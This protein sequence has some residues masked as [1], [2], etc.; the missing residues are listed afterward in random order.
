MSE[1]RSYGELENLT[2][3]ESE[4]ALCKP[5]GDSRKALR[6]YCPFHGSDK[7]RSLRVNMETGHF[8]CFA[9]G[10]WGYTEDA[11]KERG[12]LA[13]P[14]HGERVG[15]H[16]P[17]PKRVYK[18]KPEPEPRAELDALMESYR[19]ALP[20]SPGETYLL[21]RH[22]P[23]Q[24]AQ[25]LGVG[26][27]APGRWHNPKRDWK[28]G[29]LVFPHTTPTGELVNVYGRAVGDAPK[30]L[31]H[32]HLAGAKGYFNAQ[33][34]AH[35]DGP[36]TICEGAFDALALIAAGA[37]GVIA[38]F[39]V[40]GW[41]WEW[42]KEAGEMIL[43]LDSDATGASELQELAR[44]AKLRGKRIAYLEPGAYG[45]EKDASAAWSAG[46]LKLGEWEPLFSH[47]AIKPLS[48]AVV[49]APALSWEG[50]LRLSAAL[51]PKPWYEGVCMAHAYLEK[52]PAYMRSREA[53][54]RGAV[55]ELAQD[56]EPPEALA[57]QL[58]AWSRATHMAE[59]R[60]PSELPDSWK[61][62]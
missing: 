36:V 61:A 34:L 27:S 9:C 45:E 39:G 40:N 47:D 38:I 1:H 11:R 58:V 44:Q 20:G 43:A 54:L 52:G 13:N 6:A 8:K 55:R 30:S 5:V 26:Y 32:D 56:T 41:R 62:T 22:I 29:R 10:A 25:E 51:A 31:K 53:E 19:A 42:A 57:I 4:L 15:M 50:A 14:R 24:L 3:S 49:L 21:K 59:H 7:Q 46:V 18:P 60:H 2:L 12:G 16:T 37:P 35:P 33:A 17:S 28:G 23:L 48:P